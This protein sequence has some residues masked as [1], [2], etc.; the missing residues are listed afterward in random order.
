MPRS[1]RLAFFA[2]HNGSAMKAICNAC[3]KGRLDAEPVLVISNNADAS[4]LDW[5]RTCGIAT[6]HMSAK[7][8]GSNDLLDETVCDTLKKSYITHIVLSGYMRK[9]GEQTLA[10][11]DARILNVHPSLLPAFGGKGMYGDRVHTAVLDAGVSTSGAT[12]HLVT[13]N[14]DEGPVISRATCPVR[15]DDSLETLKSRVAKI[16]TELYIDTLQKIAD[17]QIDLDEVRA[18]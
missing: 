18:A 15:P 1:L 14:Y 16:E 8:L 6:Y 7:K 11:Y 17:R 12:I 4:A 5:A 9:L 3:R 10:A 2:S 13:Q